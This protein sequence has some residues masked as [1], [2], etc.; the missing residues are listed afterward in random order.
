MGPGGGHSTKL[1]PIRHLE[2]AYGGRRVRIGIVVARFNEIITRKLLESCQNTLLRHSVKPRNI[3]VVWVP[4]SFEIPTA[5]LRLAR[6]RRPDAI[7]CLG[8]V[9]RGETHHFEAVAAECAKG[10]AEVGRLSGIPTLFG[11]L[12]TDNLEQAIERAGAKMGNRGA[13]M[14]LAALEMANLM[15]QLER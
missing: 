4:G 3:T 13:D 5:A 10:I 12:T 8:C 9:I 11:V 15:R 14:A 6:S 2:G 7:V 1:P